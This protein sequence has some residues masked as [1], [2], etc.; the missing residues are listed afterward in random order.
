MS[1]T[2]LPENFCVL[3]WVGIHARSQPL[4]APCCDFIDDSFTVRSDIEE[5]QKNSALVKLKDT[6]KEGKWPKGCWQCE[7]RE[8]R[9]GSSMRQTENENFRKFLGVE[10]LTLEDV[11]K[12]KDQYFVINLAISNTCNLGCIMCGPHNSSI[13]LREQSK[14]R[15]HHFLD[16]TPGQPY[17]RPYKKIQIYDDKVDNPFKGNFSKTD[18]DKLIDSFA[19]IPNSAP[20]R[21]Q[22]HG[23][24]PSVMKEIY[25]LLE[26]I[27]EKNLQDKIQLEFNTNLEQYNPNFFDK[28]KKFNG[29]AMVS[30]DATGI[31][32]EYIRYPSKWNNVKNNIK[33]LKQEHGD[34]FRITVSPTWQ[35]LNI[36]YF[37]KMVD[38]C[39][40]V[41]VN[42][43]CTS[44][45]NFPRMLGMNNLP[46]DI[47]DKL[48]TKIRSSNYNTDDLTNDERENIIN[49][50]NSNPVVSLNET[51]K[52]LD[53][54]DKIRNLNWRQVF[55]ELH[56]ITKNLDT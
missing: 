9:S 17:T 55:P 3:P 47:K 11:E 34:R 21:I 56:T 10:E 7:L 35:I 12:N 45:L 50:M 25:Y 29:H 22:I 33:R 44:K 28:L 15:H 42:M 48:A 31:Q 1:K 37:D 54:V 32:Q 23:G 46:K 18:I 40:E 30:L 14:Y 51:V 38:F 2:K 49:Y 19:I 13:L 6:I 36:F 24:E 43:Y 8:E 41:G 53:Q 52:Y 27:L 20:P 39:N 5:Y 4:L 16:T 26:K